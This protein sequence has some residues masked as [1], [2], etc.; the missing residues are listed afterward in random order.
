MKKV[1]L[2]SILYMIFIACEKESIST[3]ILSSCV[4]TQ[5]RIMSRDT[6]FYVFQKGLQE[7]GFAKAIKINKPWEASVFATLVEDQ[8]LLHISFYTYYTE[9]AYPYNISEIIGISFLYNDINDG[10]FKLEGSL[11]IDI[12]APIARISYATT[13]GDIGLD[14]YRVEENT[15]N[16]YLEIEKIN[17]EEKKISGRLMATFLRRSPSTQFTFNRPV[18]R[19]FNG[20]FEADLV[21]RSENE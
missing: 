15:N 13:R 12:N 5:E 16:S 4:N 1:V 9:E 21:I 8:N 17:L 10:C 2:L 14:L 11:P 20:Y 18:V 7:T 3:R 19:F 6:G